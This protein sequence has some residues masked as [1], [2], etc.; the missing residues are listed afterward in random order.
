MINTLDI[1]STRSNLCG[2][3][4]GHLS[5]LEFT[6][7]RLALHLIAIAETFVNDEK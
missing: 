3:Q 5:L 2:D 4:N 7:R 6:Q 1:Q